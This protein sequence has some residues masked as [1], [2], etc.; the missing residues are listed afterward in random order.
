MAAAM[1]AME[2]E[3]MAAAMET[4][5]AAAAIGVRLLMMARGY[6]MLEKRHRRIVDNA[7]GGIND[8]DNSARA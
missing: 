8:S 6:G 1:A 7:E 4:A 2:S 5:M 3:A